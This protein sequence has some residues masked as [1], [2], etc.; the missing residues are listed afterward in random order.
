MCIRDRYYEDSSVAIIVYD[1]TSAASFQVLKNWIEEINEKGPKD[2]VIAIAGNKCDLV[3]KEEVSYDEAFKYAK[4]ENAIFK[5]TSAKENQGIGE[6]FTAI[7]SKLENTNLSANAPTKKQ[8]GVSLKNPNTA[9]AVS[10]THLTLP[11]KRIVQISVVVVSLKKKN[12]THI[13]YNHCNHD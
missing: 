11:T 4:S 12:K 6:L 3:E 8:Q 10:Y 7:A 2:I 5:L 9:K 1:I 13:R